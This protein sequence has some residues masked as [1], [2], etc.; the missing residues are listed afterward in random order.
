MNNLF[1][2]PFD[3]INSNGNFVII[4]IKSKK[5][6]V[7]CIFVVLNGKIYGTM[8]E[9]FTVSKGVLVYSFNE[10]LNSPD[11]IYKWLN[12][13]IEKWGLLKPENFELIQIYLNDRLIDEYTNSKNVDLDSIS[14]TI[15]RKLK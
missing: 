5:E 6:N 13:N 14:L 11:K 3:T 2:I 8:F 15:Y 9:I 4:D 10:P 1:M 7:K 12:K